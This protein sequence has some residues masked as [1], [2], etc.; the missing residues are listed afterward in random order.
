MTQPDLEIKAITNS[1]TQII[2]ITFQLRNLLATIGSSFT[3]YPIESNKITI[4]NY[5]SDNN[6]DQEHD[7]WAAVCLLSHP[8]VQK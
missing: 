2:P 8:Y 6:I 7:F 5:I 4:F 1:I 3:R